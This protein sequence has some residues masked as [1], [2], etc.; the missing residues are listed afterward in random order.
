MYRKQ[1]I[2]CYCAKET[3]QENQCEIFNFVDLCS[4]VNSVWSTITQMWVY[5]ATAVSFS[6]QCLNHQNS[7]RY[8]KTYQAC[9]LLHTFHLLITI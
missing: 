1:K 2:N 3:D 9:G 4:W 8:Q 6:D 7:I 5:A